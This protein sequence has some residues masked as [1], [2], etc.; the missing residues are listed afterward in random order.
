MGNWSSLLRLDDCCVV[1]FTST[2]AAL[3]GEKVMKKTG[4]PFVIMPTPR[5][6]STSCGLSIKVRPQDIEF[7]FQELKKSGVDIEGVFR[8]TKKGKKK[9]ISAVEGLLSKADD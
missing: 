1:T 8:M 6:I 3:K 2:S 4:P 7:C 9:E 5:E